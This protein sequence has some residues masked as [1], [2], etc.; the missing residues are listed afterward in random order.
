MK[1]VLL[2]GALG[3]LG[4]E[5]ASRVPQSIDFK[6]FTKAEL[7]ISLESDINRVITSSAPRYCN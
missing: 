3:Q 7:D 6:A 5:I 2:L 1:K 4:R